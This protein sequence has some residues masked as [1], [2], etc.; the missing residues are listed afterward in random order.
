MGAL[1]EQSGLEPKQ[2][3]PKIWNKF[4]D[5]SQIQGYIKQITTGSLLKDMGSKELADLICGVP[6]PWARAKMFRWALLSGKGQSNDGLENV[7]KQLVGEWRGL[8]ALIALYPSRVRFGNPIYMKTKIEESDDINQIAPSFGRMLFHED[9]MLWNDHELEEY[10]RKPFIQLIYYHNE[11]SGVVP[12]VV[13]ATSPYTG[14]FTGVDYKLGKD[15]SINWYRNGKFD[16]PVA[17]GVLDQSSLEKLYIYINNWLKD[18]FSILNSFRDRIY[19]GLLGPDKDDPVRETIGE[20]LLNWRKEIKSKCD[21]LKGLAPNDAEAIVGQIAMYDE[22]KHRN[23]NPHDAFSI[24]FKGKDVPVYV[25]LKDYSF[26]YSKSDNDNFEELG[27]TDDLLSSDVSVIGWEDSKLADAPVYYLKADNKNQYFTIPLSE[28]GL[29][30][31]KGRMGDLLTPGKM[32]GASLTATVLDGDKLKVT[33]TLRIDSQETKVEMEYEIDWF[34]THVDTK[35]ST[36][37]TW[38]NFISEDWSKYY[39]FSEFTSEADLHFS[40]IFFIWENRIHGKTKYLEKEKLDEDGKSHIFVY[41][42]GDDSNIGELDITSLIHCPANDSSR[43]KYN[44]YSSKLPIAGLSVSVKGRSG[45]GMASHAGYLLIKEGHERSDI[46]NIDG[47]NLKPVT[48]GFDFGSNNSCVY[49]KESTSSDIEPKPINFGRMRSVLVGEENDDDSSEA[50]H[51]ELLFYSGY[52][53]VDPKENAN[54]QVKSWLHRHPYN[55]LINN[56]QIVNGIPVNRPNITVL[57]MDEKIIRTECGELYYNMKWLNTDEKNDYIKSIWIQVCAYLFVK[58]YYA[59]QLNWSYPS[60]KTDIEDI[61]Q[62]FES[63]HDEQLEFLKKGHELS[64]NQ[65]GLTEA[66]SVCLYASSPMTVKDISFSENNLFLGIDVGGSTSDILVMNKDTKEKH[67]PWIESSV[68]LS[69]G[70]FFKAVIESRRF[71]QALMNFLDAGKTNVHVQGIENMGNDG[72][73]APFYLNSIFDQLTTPQDFKEFYNSIWRDAKFVFAIPAYVTGFLLYYSGML[74]GDHLSLLPDLGE[75]DKVK[76][77]NIL[78]FGK[79]GRLFHWL[80]NVNKRLADDYYSKCLSDGIN[81]MY[82]TTKNI[83][84]ISSIEKHSKSE[85]AWGLCLSDGQNKDYDGTYILCEE[86]VEYQ[87]KPLEWY[88]QVQG[89]WFDNLND[90]EFKECPVFMGF[91]DIYRDF[92]LK[93]HIV[94]S[95]NDLDEL[96]KKMETA[97]PDMMKNFIESDSDYRAAREAWAK[98]STE[99]KSKHEFGYRQPALVIEASRFLQELIGRIFNN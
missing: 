42:D 22:N 30:V 84:Y 1:L 59:K 48:V 71:Q 2:G 10:N 98:K 78:A 13:G 52:P 85:V 58:G 50:R 32:L 20:N 31:F 15:T 93:S 66:E 77:I 11:N 79:G 18:D 51:N 40:P 12:C 92:C 70:V 96:H 46:K 91:F 24:L 36:I 63:L 54:G 25:D 81:T 41:H 3:S 80:P 27:G 4:P 47:K 83:R 87:G 56:D 95:S 62:A 61:H 17:L 9:R 21:R 99:E 35:S 55:D 16:D 7:Y 88:D 53:Y 89:Q 73:V 49:F 38:P 26:H 97:L 60:A 67:T 23:G 74:I 34:Q 44:I 65:N 43:F 28:N 90:L 64:V 39:F 8:L 82:E 6:S 57:S 29:R 33:L 69:A 5:K 72:Y 76:N 94:D 68:R 19:E 45:N 37:V 86:G 75:E 14:C